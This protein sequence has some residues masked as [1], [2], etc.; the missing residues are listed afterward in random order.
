MSSVASRKTCKYKNASILMPK[1]VGGGGSAALVVSGC[2][3]SDTTVD[4]VSGSIG[5]FVLHFSSEQHSATQ[6]AKYA[7]PERVPF[8]W[9]QAEVSVL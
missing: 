9:L 6:R 2:V 5:R 1:A 8:L 7:G 3:V 4:E